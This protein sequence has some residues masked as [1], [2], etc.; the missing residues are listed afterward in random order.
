MKKVEIGKGRFYSDGKFGLREVLDEGPQYRSY[1]GLENDDC[2]RYRCLNAKSSSD[3]GLERNSTRAAFAAWAKEEVP[4]LQVRAAMLGMQAKTVAKKLT[5]AQRDFL[6]T[7]DRGISEHDLV[8]CERGEYRLAKG[9]HGKGVIAKLPDRLGPD[10]A[11]FDVAFTPLG[12][13]VLSA[14]Q[15]GQG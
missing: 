6:L 7:F 8:E 5:V 3:V 14:L 4:S 13:A 1:E 9:C 11:T 2:L 15:N 10:V 12:A